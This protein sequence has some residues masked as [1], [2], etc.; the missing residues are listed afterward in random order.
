METI[1]EIRFKNTTPNIHANK[2]DFFI[3]AGIRK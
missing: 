3:D 2:L 1:K